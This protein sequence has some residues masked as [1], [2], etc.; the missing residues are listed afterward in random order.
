M[1]AITL[2]IPGAPRTKKTHSRVVR[3]GYGRGGKIRVIP[4]EQWCA[5][6]EAATLELAKIKRRMPVAFPLRQDFNCT[7]LFY[8]DANR[9]D[10]VGYYQGLADLLQE[11]KVLADDVQI[12]HWDGSRLLKDADN[13]RVEVTLTP[14]AA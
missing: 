10:A 4:S 12:V 11:A 14:I 9:G 8:R 5:W 3:A 13:P 1:K 2:V 6:A 7:A